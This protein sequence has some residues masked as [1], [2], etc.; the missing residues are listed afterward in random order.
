[1]QSTRHSPRPSKSQ[2]EGS[3]MDAT[4]TGCS[5]VAWPGGDGGVIDVGG[6]SVATG[7]ESSVAS[8]D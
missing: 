3:G 5:W 2:L 8:G 1:M 4:M 7:G 6:E